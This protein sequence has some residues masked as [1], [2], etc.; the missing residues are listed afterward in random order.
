MD[1]NEMVALCAKQATEKGWNIKPI[2][3]PEMIALIHSEA[4]EALES[5]RNK[6]P[7]SWTQEDVSGLKPMGIASEFA[8]ILIRIGHYSEMLGID[9]EREVI[10]KLKYNSQRPYRHGGKLA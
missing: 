8:D 4:S 5:F 7:L 6:E 1:I 3:V 10:A 9:L 2:P